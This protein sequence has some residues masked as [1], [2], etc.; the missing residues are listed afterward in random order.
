VVWF[1]IEDRGA[2]IRRHR[3]DDS[4][5]RVITRLI[6]ADLIIVDDIGLLPVSPDAAEGF[7]RLIDAAYERRAMAVSSNLHPSGFDEI[8]PK[9]LATATVDRLLHTRMS[10]SP[11]EIAS[12]WPK[13]PQGT[14][15]NRCTDPPGDAGY[16]ARCRR[17]RIRRTAMTVPARASRMTSRAM[18]GRG[19]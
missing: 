6:R 4:I 1:T 19:A 11:K 7:Y 8:M 17:A 15:S 13:P 12:G 18:S 16:G 10:L 5:A 14:A 3:V 9:T 2:L